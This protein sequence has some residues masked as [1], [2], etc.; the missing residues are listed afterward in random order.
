MSLTQDDVLKIMKMLHNSR[1]NELRLEMDGIKLF[2]SKKG[3][4]FCE[5]TAERNLAAPA[6][7]TGAGASPAPAAPQSEQAI[8]EGLV[9]IRSPMLGVFYRAPKPGERPFV[10]EG[11]AVEKGTTLCIIEVMKLYS[12]ITAELSGRIA[13]VCAQDGQMV[14]YGQ[15]LFLIEP[16]V[17]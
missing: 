4:S 7:L 2:L 16:R 14:E 17:D 3:P 10:E 8:P 15:P 9:P 1:F 12:T 5:P 11:A 6:S 13:R